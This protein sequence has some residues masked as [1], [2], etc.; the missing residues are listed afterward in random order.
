MLSVAVAETC[1]DESHNRSAVVDAYKLSR[2]DRRGRRAGGV[3][4]DVRGCFDCLGITIVTT[5]LNIYGL[6]SGGRVT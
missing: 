4:L 5:G 2:R 1:W 6:E 3:A